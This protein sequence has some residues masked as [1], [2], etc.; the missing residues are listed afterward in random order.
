MNVQGTIKSTRHQHDDVIKWKH[1]PRYWTF[2]RGIY[3]SPVNSPHKDQWRR[4]LMFSLICD[5]INDRDFKR[6]HAHYDV[7]VLF[8]FVVVTRR[9]VW[10]TRWRHGVMEIR[11]KACMCNFIIRAIHAGTISFTDLYYMEHYIVLYTLNVIRLS[12]RNVLLYFF[13]LICFYNFKTIYG[14]YNEYIK[15]F[16]IE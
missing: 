15:Q 10:K 11:Y 16:T 7:S 8:L 5:W 6:Y 1:F 13:H 14:W 9:H 3:R 12:I 2:V 4:A